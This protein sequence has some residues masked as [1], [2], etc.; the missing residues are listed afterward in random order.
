[1]NNFTINQEI[2]LN[3]NTSFCK[4]DYTEKEPGKNAKRL[5]KKEALKTLCWDGALPE[6]LPEICH[7][8]GSKPL[9]LW[10]L[11]E[12]EN[13]LHLKLGEYQQKIE[14]AF[15]INAYLLADSLPLN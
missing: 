3:T 2:L 8:S 5:S 15:S 11:L 1:M 12:T 13:L 14:H 10:E 4:R 7:I 6:L 9:I